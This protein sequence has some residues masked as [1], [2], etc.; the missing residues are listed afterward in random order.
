MITFFTIPR[1]FTGEFDA[2]QRAAIESWIN[3][4]TCEVLL[5]GDVEGAA[6]M[7]LAYHAIR[8][9][10]D[11]ATNEHGTPLV[12]DAFRIADAC[13]DYDIICEVSADV[14]LELPYSVLAQIHN[15]ERPFVVGQRW[16]QD[17]DGNRKLHSPLGIDYFLYRRGTLGEIP[18]FAVGRTG[19]DNWLAWAAIKRWDMTVI[20]AT[21]AI[22]AVHHEHGYHEYG[23][24]AKMLASEERRENLRLMAAT[25]CH[26]IYGVHHAP[27]VLNGEGVQRR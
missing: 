23:T 26:V 22:T 14:S 7:Q 3:T 18:P 27:Y 13:A 20:D 6:D 16:D 17:A 5:I 15:T 24:R 2:I 21:Q 12:N 11:V 4:W 8:H 25:G 1:A 9:T 10:A 19:Y